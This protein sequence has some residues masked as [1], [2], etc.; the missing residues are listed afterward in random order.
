M[1]YLIINVILLGITIYLM[2]DMRSSHKKL[3][4]TNSLSDEVR[5][6]IQAERREEEERR[7][8]A[9]MI[10]GVVS[11]AEMDRLLDTYVRVPP[12]QTPPSAGTGIRHFALADKLALAPSQ[13]KYGLSPKKQ[14]EKTK[15][16][17]KKSGSIN[18]RKV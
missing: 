5:R 15:K 12:P 7:Y 16:K 3:K 8:N 11:A 17:K 6:R 10:S 4:E 18:F 1:I 2:I 9:P 13:A 14:E